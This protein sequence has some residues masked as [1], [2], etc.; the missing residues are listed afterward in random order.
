MPTSSSPSTSP[1][2]TPEDIPPNLTKVGQKALHVFKTK[3][4][5]AFF[6]SCVRF[7]IAIPASLIISILLNDP[8]IGGFACL[9]SFM[10]LLADVRS[11][12]STRLIC[13][14]IVLAVVAASVIVGYLCS[15]I[16]F[17]KWIVIAICGIGCGLLPV[18]EFFWWAVS[19]YFLI[20]L[21]VSLFDFAPDASALIGYLL[22]YV[23]SV[24]VIIID[25]YMWK[26]NQ[27]GTRPIE[28][29]RDI[30]NGTRNS[31][32]FA[33]ISG[34]ILFFSLWTGD[35][36]GLQQLA[37]VGIAV[38]YLLGTKISFGLKRSYQRV[39]GTALG[40]AAVVAIFS[41]PVSY[42]LY[43]LGPFIVLF[44]TPIP[45]FIVKD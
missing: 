13:S 2:P 35:L 5:L 19:K 21:M 9:S 15:F 4:N 26:L 37:W 22:G 39:V 33:I 20:F 34:L 27:L 28:Q 17:G 1:S 11:K 25:H 38:I 40:Y 29:I 24:L 32:S 43:V 36:F 44:A 3:E 41:T 30:I 23:V 42:N 12:L 6:A 45:Y 16:S 8:K 10:V 31:W 18:A 14:V 7:F